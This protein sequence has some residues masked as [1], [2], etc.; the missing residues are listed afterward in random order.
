[1]K[2]LVPNFFTSSNLG[3]GVLSIILTA[4]GDLFYGALCILGSLVADALD[5]R[6]ARA[7][8]VSGEFGKELDSLGDVVSFGT[9]S[10][11]LIYTAALQELGWIG[12][13]AA[14]I[15]AVCGGLRLA[16]FNLNTTVVH[17]YFMGVP[18]PTGGCLFA[19]FVLSGVH[20]PAGLA[21]VL[22]VIMGYL[23][24]SKVHNPDFKGK[25]ADVLHKSALVA[26]LVIGV[27]LMYVAGW[28]IIVCLPFALYVVFGLINTAINTF[29]K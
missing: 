19:T 27:V 20:I 12:A 11:F 10:A 13:L 6:S 1:M 9:A 4:K 14:I 18:I 7:L 21:A 26:A 2:S 28:Q 24:V 29:G 8:G 16:R 17:G 3:F 5:G 25:S 15:Y 23:L 22:V